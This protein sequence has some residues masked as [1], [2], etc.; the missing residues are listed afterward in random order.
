MRQV[1]GFDEHDPRLSNIDDAHQAKQENDSDLQKSAGSVPD[2]ED[3]DD[4]D[5]GDLQ[6]QLD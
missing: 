4:D 5:A 1:L 2:F 3:E 6:K